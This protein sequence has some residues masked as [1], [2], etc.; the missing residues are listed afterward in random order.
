[1][2]LQLRGE[3]GGPCEAALLHLWRGGEEGAHGG[4]GGVD[5]EVVRDGAR[6]EGFSARVGRGR[7]LE[8][9]EE[10]AAVEGRRRGLCGGG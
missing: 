4:D 5:K 6:G 7:V 10:E 9:A 1:V 3:G 2:L 8:E